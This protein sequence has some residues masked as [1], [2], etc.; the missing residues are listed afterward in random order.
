MDKK[1]ILYID[2]DEVLCDFTGHYSLKHWDKTKRNPPAMYE[3]GFF[4]DLQPLS[5]AISSV[6]KIL[7]SNKYDVYILTQ[8]VAKSPISYTEKVNWVYKYLPDLGGKI[9]MTQDKSLIKGNFLIDDSEKW[10]SFEGEF[11]HFKTDIH[12][13]EMW[14]E[15]LKI[16]DV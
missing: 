9:I 8:P 16:L 3:P 10:R 4:E 7:N 1:P 14:N 11:I 2:M 12:P 6:I 5:G 13:L 15:I